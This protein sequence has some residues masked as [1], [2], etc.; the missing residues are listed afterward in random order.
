MPIAEKDYS[1]ILSNDVSSAWSNCLFIQ[2]IRDRF[3]STT[4]VTEISNSPAFFADATGTVLLPAI[5]PYQ[6][7]HHPK[8]DISV[9]LPSEPVAATKSAR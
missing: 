9:S 5:E 4:F 6:T 8:C 3:V 7:S 2:A 1:N